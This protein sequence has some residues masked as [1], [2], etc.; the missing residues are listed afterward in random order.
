MDTTSDELE[1][2][3]VCT[4]CNYCFLSEPFASD[5]V[6]CLND[7]EFEPYLDEILEEQD[8]SRCQD[9]VKQ[10]RFSWEQEACPDFDPMEFSDEDIPLSPELSNAIDQLAKD[11]NL[12]SETI[13]QA[14]FED[15]VDEIDWAKVPVEKYVERLDNAKTPEARKKAVQS[16]GGLISQKNK[17]AFNALFSYLKDLPPP[18]TVEQTHLRIE[19]LRQL[20]FTLNFQ[21]KLARLLVKDLFRTPSNNTTRGWYTAVFRFFEGS[22]ADIAEEALAPMLGSPQFSY[23]IKERVKNI[24]ERPNDYW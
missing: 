7:P 4:N 19:I 18:T 17:A 15:M 16:F 13:Q 24:L 10:K 23:R 5:F 21:K 8:F 11:G 9:L 12:T 1:L 20:K 6:I 2:E 3:R 14:I 22:S